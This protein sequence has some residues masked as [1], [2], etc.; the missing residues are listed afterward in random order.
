MIQFATGSFFQNIDSTQKATTPEVATALL[1]K[2]LSDLAQ[3]KFNQADPTFDG[4]QAWLE[5]IIRVGGVHPPAP[6]YPKFKES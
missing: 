6:E 2:F 5:L 1:N 3:D 4:Y